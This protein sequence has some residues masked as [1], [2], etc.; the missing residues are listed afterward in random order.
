MIANGGNQILK[1]II[2]KVSGQNLFSMGSGHVETVVVGSGL[3]GLTTTLQLLQKGREVVLIEKTDKL[4]GNSIKAS[5]GINAVDSPE[6]SVES[7]V[8]DTLISGKGLCNE[9]LVNILAANSRK[10]LNWLTL[11]ENGI[12]LLVLTQLGGHSYPRTHRGSGKLPP[13]FAIISQLSSKLQSYSDGPDKKLTILKETSLERILLDADER[14]SGVEYSRGEEK[15]TIYCDNLVLATGGYSAG[16]TSNSLLSRFRPDL[17]SFP[18]TNG[19]QTV[20]EGQIIAERD[21]GA[22]LIHM[23]QI[24]LHPTGFIK[25]GDVSSKFKFLGGEL[26]RGIGGILLSPNSSRRFVNELTTRDLVTEA[27]LSN[28][29]IDKNQLGIAESTP[30]AVVV[31]NQSDYLKAKSHI[32]FYTKQGLMFEGHIDDLVKLLDKLNPLLAFSTG[33]IRETFKKY[34]HA[35]EDVDPFGRKSFGSK[36]EENEIFYYGLV[37]PVLH[38][39]MGGIE[40]NKY[41]QVINKNAQTVENLFAVG[42]VSGGVHGGNRLGGSSLLECVVFGTVVSD[43]IINN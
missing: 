5:S 39:S 30:V 43:A 18:L 10:A 31:I 33:E 4:G 2:S 37:T 40:I 42:E 12:D 22:R 36:F 41:G 28:C 35:V 11:E 38:F 27:I 16:F 14:I 29:R 21:A 24:Q 32:D 7:F 25:L 19:P 9:Q 15:Q 23:D 13:G 1:R 26:L 8:K 17:L 3:A 6:D 20:G 34:D